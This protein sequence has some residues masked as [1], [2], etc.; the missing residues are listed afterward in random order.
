M[1]FRDSSEAHLKHGLGGV[2]LDV[3]SVY[4]DLDDAVPDLLADVV[5]SDA[6]QVQDGVHVPGV[7]HGVL[8]RQDGHF[9]DLRKRSQRLKKSAHAA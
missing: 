1:A 7:V 6:D 3:V 5:P 4:D 8:L 2:T 9:E